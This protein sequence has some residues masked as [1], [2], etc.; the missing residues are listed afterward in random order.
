MVKRIIISETFDPAYN[1]GLEEYLIDS[2]E[3]ILYLWQN[4]NTIVIGRNQNPYKECNLKKMKE[5]D[6]ALVR[7]KSGG[8]A[9]FHDLGNLNF[10]IISPKRED[11]IS[12]NFNLVNEALRNLNID[13]VFNGRNDLHVDGKKISGNA[14]YEK[15]NIF[16][17]H[18]TLLIDVNMDKL[19][20]YLTASK[21][22]LKSKGINSVKSRV[23]NLVDLN[24]EI[25]IEAVKDVLINGYKSVNTDTDIEI[26]ILSK[27]DIGSNDKIMEKVHLYKS[28]KWLFGESPK[29]NISYEEKFE[30]GIINLE[31]DVESGVIKNAKIYTDSIINDNFFELGKDLVGKEFKKQNVIN[32]IEN[33]INSKIIKENLIGRINDI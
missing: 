17:H 30:F 3:E 12:S 19:S 20:N 10:T 16:C 9:V 24:K 2:G 25:D 26:E 4:D 21:L 27:D 11:N 29:S 13:S 33:N 23:V 22:K 6:I 28:W 31:L 1:L 32:S 5:D 14:F 8:G 7:R 15:D 18:G